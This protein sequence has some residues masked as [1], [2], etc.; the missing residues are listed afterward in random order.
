MG[1][2]VVYRVKLGGLSLARTDDTTTADLSRPK[3]QAKATASQIVAMTLYCAS[4]ENGEEVKPVSTISSGHDLAIRWGW[5]PM[6][7]P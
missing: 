7:G 3:Q 4:D 5:R 1:T 2:T 6:S